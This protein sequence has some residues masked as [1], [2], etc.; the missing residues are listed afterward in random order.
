MRVLIANTEQLGRSEY[1]ESVFDLTEPRWKGR[2]AA[3]DVTNASWIGFVTE[4][5]IKRG[6]RRRAAGS[7]G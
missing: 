2:V 6:E 3:P 7:R 4:L 5:R 1:P